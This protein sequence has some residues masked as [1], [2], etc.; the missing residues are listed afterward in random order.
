MKT[1]RNLISAVTFSFTAKTLTLT[2][3]T[4]V[5]LRR[6][7]SIINLTR[8]VVYFKAADANLVPTITGNVITLNASV[9]TV[10]HADTDQIH[11]AY[12]EDDGGIIPAHWRSAKKWMISTQSALGNASAWNN[13][14]A[15]FAIR[16]TNAF[17]VRIITLEH[18]ARNTN[19]SAVANNQNLP[20]TASMF[21]AGAG[22]TGGTALSV[23]NAKTYAVDAT[24]VA[25]FMPTVSGTSVPIADGNITIVPYNSAAN[26]PAPVNP[27]NAPKW[28]EGLI[29]P[30]GGMLVLYGQPGFG[31][32]STT[33]FCN[34]SAIL[35][36]DLLG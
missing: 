21:L 35:T 15:T 12:V 13:G 6:I 31:G 23:V 1:Q 19:T 18:C 2:G 24:I 20:M 10:G 9:F 25:S 7:V 28:A 5:E 34:L 14:V 32:S 11:V 22:S 8:G 26:L 33:T 3:L 17:P 36:D 4:T 30:A 27:V 29:I 16:N